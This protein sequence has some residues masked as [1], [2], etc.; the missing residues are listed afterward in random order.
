MSPINNH[1]GILYDPST[2]TPEPPLT[3]FASPTMTTHCH[4]CLATSPH[5]HA[6]TT[7]FVC[8]V[9][10][11]DQRQPDQL[12]HVLSNRTILES[13][14]NDYIN[15]TTPEQAVPLIHQN[16]ILLSNRA[17]HKVTLRLCQSCHTA[18]TQITVNQN[19]Y[20]TEGTTDDW[21]EVAHAASQMIRKELL[22]NIVANTFASINTTTSN[23]H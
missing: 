6:T 16:D 18:A 10:Q 12:F 13:Y 11:S 9:H 20:L 4:S 7:N 5:P 15:N 17:L 3:P 2:L 23:S 14:Y 1:Y 8:I 22:K 21:N 19:G